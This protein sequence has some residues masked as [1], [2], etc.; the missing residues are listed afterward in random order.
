MSIQHGV[1]VQRF[2]NLRRGTFNQT[3]AG[4]FGETG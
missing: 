3:I 2:P 4:V 1:I